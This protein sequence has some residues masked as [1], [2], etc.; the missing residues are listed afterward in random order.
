MALAASVIERVAPDRGCRA[1]DSEGTLA[2]RN[3]RRTT[4]AGAASTELLLF[5][6][7][8]PRLGLGGPGS[9]GVTDS[10]AGSPEGG[11]LRATEDLGTG[12]S[13]GH[14]VTRSLG[15]AILPSPDHEQVRPRECQLRAGLGVRQILSKCV[16]TDPEE[17]RQGS[18]VSLVRTAPIAPSARP[19]ACR[20]CTRHGC[21]RD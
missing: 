17:P 10:E 7:C 1:R 14:T 8:A 11:S 3:A 19:P 5:C 4:T 15:I 18:F 13:A 16:P 2:L 20:P 12:C 9:H 6:T 21:H